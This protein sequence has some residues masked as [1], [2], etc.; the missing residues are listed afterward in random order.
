MRSIILIN[1]LATTQ[2]FSC[3]DVMNDKRQLWGNLG[4]V[5]QIES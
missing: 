5:A 2:L 1:R 4:H 3:R